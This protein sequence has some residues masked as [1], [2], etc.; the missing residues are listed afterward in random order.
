MQSSNL[1]G[2]L[3]VESAPWF[4]VP[5]DLVVSFMSEMC[6]RARPPRQ[7]YGGVDR[8]GAVE[9]EDISILFLL[10]YRSFTT[11]YLFSLMAWR[12]I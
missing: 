10:C 2:S 5:K 8:A 4:L 6:V 7:Q 11:V 3:M 12:P 9:A 1:S